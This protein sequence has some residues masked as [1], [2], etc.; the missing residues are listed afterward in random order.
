M[1]H[2]PSYLSKSRHDVYYFRYPFGNKR[3]KLS[4]HTRCPKQALRLAKALAYHS[5]NILAGIDSERMDYAEAKAMIEASFAKE[6]ARQKG[7]IDRSGPLPDKIKKRFLGMIELAGH[8]LGQ[9]KLDD[10]WFPEDEDIADI[11]KEYTLD[12]SN[13]EKDRQKLKRAHLMGSKAVLQQLLTY[14]DSCAEFDFS[15]KKKLLAATESKLSNI[16]N[17]YMD[18]IKSGL[19]ERAFEDQRDCLQYLIDWLGADF[20]ISK[21]DDAKARQVKTLLRDTP[22]GRNK[23]ALTKGKSIEEQIELG[24]QNGLEVISPVSV[25][26]Y[27]TY[28][29]TLFKWAKRNRYITENPFTDLRMKAGSKK[30]RR[31]KNF[32]KEEVVQVIQHLSDDN[33]VKNKSNYW[34]ALIAV[35][36][37][38]RRNEIAGLLP[39]D[40]KQD[41]ESGI[42]YFD[43]TDEAEEGKNLKTEAAKRIVPVHPHLIEK[44]FLDFVEQ[45]RSVKGKKDELAPRL[46][47]H[48]TYTEHEKWG[49]NLGRW[50]NES[51]LKGIG[52]K[53]DKKTLHSLRHSFITYLS[54]SGVDGAIIK[55]LVGHESDSVTS[56]TYTHYGLDHLRTFRDA[57]E[58]L[59]Y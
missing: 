51:Y 11:V 37:G 7:M 27:L 21:L 40:V 34:G 35:Y 30:E 32:A 16:V 59:P 20:Q 17:A 46:L 36:T 22:K 19:S 55:S 31:R 29:D 23:A 5:E 3:I 38:A 1:R 2:N 57:I 56:A 58:K 45:S 8:Y 48:L 42:W 54:A 41:K 26:K 49:R 24:K 4:L 43:I 33:R 6:L 28:F 14:S 50:F 9:E 15:G 53:T 52:L 13:S 12:L 25:N 44:G 10:D 47:H 18:E 39:D